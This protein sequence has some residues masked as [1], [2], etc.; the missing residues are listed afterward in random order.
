MSC[1]RIIL[2][3]PT[4]VASLPDTIKNNGLVEFDIDSS[5]T[6]TLVQDELSDIN[7][8]P[9]ET[10]KSFNLPD[11]E[12]NR[13]ISKFAFSPNA[14]NSRYKK[15]IRVKVQD[16]G[17]VLKETRITIT[18]FEG[19]DDSL[20]GRI[21]TDTWK[22]A[23]SN[24][25][26]NEIKIDNYESFTLER[27]FIESSWALGPYVDGGNPFRFGLINYG[28][29][30]K[31]DRVVV[32]DMRPVVSVLAFL[33]AG[34]CKIG[35]N[36]ESSI[37]ESELGR[38][39]FAYF[40]DKTYGNDKALIEEH[41]FE[42]L[43]R[44]GNT[45]SFRVD[46]Q[47]GNVMEF[48][49]I[50]KD[51]VGWNPA[52]WEFSA[53]GSYKFYGN[54]IF[55]DET[56]FLD[57]Q[58]VTVNLIKRTVDNQLISLDLEG[59]RMSK[60]TTDYYVNVESGYVT[61]LDGEAVFLEV[62][63]YNTSDGKLDQVAIWGRFYN[64]V[65]SVFPTRGDVLDTCYIFN[66]EIT[67]LQ[68]IKDLTIATGGMFQESLLDNT[69]YWRPPYFSEVVDDDV[70]GHYIDEITDLVDIQKDESDFSS[71][72]DEQKR[73]VILAYADSNDP[74]Y[75]QLPTSFVDS[76]SVDGNIFGRKIDLGESFEDGED[77]RKM[78][79][80]EPT[81]NTDSGG[82]VGDTQGEFPIVPLMTDNTDKEISF[83]FGIRL[84][85]WFGLN[86]M[87]FDG[88][89]TR[90]WVWE[91][92]DQLIGRTAVPLL[93]QFIEWGLTISTDRRFNNIFGHV[94]D[95]TYGYDLYHTLLKRYLYE[96]IDNP[97]CGASVYLTQEKLNCIAHLRGL[98]TLKIEGQ[99]T[100]LRIK[101][102]QGISI[103]EGTPTRV[104]GYKPKQEIPSYLCAD[105]D[106]TIERLCNSQ[107]NP[108]L[109]CTDLMNGCFQIDLDL[110]DVASPVLLTEWSVQFSGGLFA[111]LGDNL[112]VT[113]ICPM[114]EIGIVKVKITYDE[115]EGVTCPPQIRTAYKSTVINYDPQIRCEVMIDENQNQV[116]YYE[117]GPELPDTCILT[118]WEV[119]AFDKD[120]GISLFVMPLGALAGTISGAARYVFRATVECGDCD[121]IEVT[122][123]CCLPVED[124][125]Q[126]FE[127]SIDKGIVDN[128]IIEDIETF[129][130]DLLS[131]YNGYNGPYNLPGDIGLFE[132]EVANWLLA[133]GNQNPQVEVIDNSPT[134]CIIKIYCIQSNIASI[135]SIA[136]VIPR[137]TVECEECPPIVFDP[138]CPE[139]FPQEV[140]DLTVACLNT[141][142]GI[143]AVKVGIVPLGI[144]PYVGLDT[145]EFRCSPE[146]DW[147]LWD[148]EPI[149]AEECPEVCFRRFILWCDNI[150]VTYCGPEVCCGCEGCFLGQ[151]E[152]FS[153]FNEEFIDLVAEFG[154]GGCNW[155][156]AVYTGDVDPTYFNNGIF[157]PE[158]AQPFGDTFVINIS[159][160]MGD[161]CI[162]EG[163]AIIRL[164]NEGK[165][166]VNRHNATGTIRELW[167]YGDL[168][169][170]GSKTQLCP[171][172]ANIYR[173]IA[174][175]PN[176]LIYG[177]AD[178]AG[179]NTEIWSI[180]PITCTEELVCTLLKPSG[181]ITQ[182]MVA[183]S[184]LPNGA[185]VTGKANGTPDRY[186][187]WIIKD[188]LVSCKTAIWTTVPIGGGTSWSNTGDVVVFKGKGYAAFYDSVSNNNHLFEFDLDA[189]FNVIG[190][191]LLGVTFVGSG[192]S[193]V[194]GLALANGSLYMARGNGEFYRI[195]DL[196]TTPIT[197]VLVDG[198][199][200]QW[201]GATGTGEYCSE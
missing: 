163:T 14:G 49:I 35:K 93:A 89:D 187:M 158:D 55:W 164:E 62:R 63:V 182:N 66:K 70:E 111:D 185:L 19:E 50:V 190:Q 9:F 134:S 103:C 64:E 156:V 98:V 91:D 122:Q 34:F 58:D 101:E 140:L 39:Q 76:F 77:E 151:L 44:E 184:F 121:P 100:N 188:F 73:F 197:S 69:V 41:K 136:G 170:T 153:C 4:L 20:V 161:D 166:Y 81:L 152:I 51:S 177:T 75:D 162:V 78:D 199:T 90:K 149:D 142:E 38:R 3:E 23:A 137:V 147:E 130:G 114:C 16:G 194:W 198:G 138:I 193:Q 6:R 86:E 160:D 12:K 84:L 105:P 7:E 131:D 56:Q 112:T 183:L 47:D 145:I 116:L 128:N 119:E 191:T 67:F 127:F 168:P 146:D 53:P 169:T 42:V 107:N 8:F 141:D 79:K 45:N 132:T 36:F 174:Y 118:T 22:K 123:E 150:C 32:E 15:G 144:K 54:I 148:G 74:S 11:T 139:D 173:D 10:N 196:T 167:V 68:F 120:T 85:T 29:F 17:Q 124:I 57:F 1:V 27:A 106:A 109:I 179:G 189:D 95:D 195:T 87:S 200:S 88:G 117:L 178:A 25:K 33:K 59:V 13:L 201:W 18:D 176:G 186:E 96:N 172:L 94:N 37:W 97:V 129:G 61:I 175:H 72:N 80:I 30:I 125:L 181:A 171:S 192:P 83:D 126:C 133:L 110:S 159:I 26:L 65:F 102:L 24:C 52:T 71:Y 108:Q 92:D 60:A 82:P 154:G 46:N 165:V 157:T 43:R 99:S 180:N 28:Q 143:I 21:V 40:L 113:V 155:G 5:V 115:Q 135:T 2:N 48:D 104:V 31:F